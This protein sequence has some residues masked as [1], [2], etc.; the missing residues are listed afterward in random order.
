VK[1]MAAMAEP[2]YIDVAPHNPSGPI[3]NAATLQLAGCI[4][5]F[6]ILEIMLNDVCWR[7]E[8]TDEEVAFQS[9]NIL[10]P[11]KPGLGLDINEENCLKYPFKPI[12]LRHYKGTLTDVRP[13]GSQTEYYFKNFG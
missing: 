12:Q 11:D 9:G 1:K 4:N 3:A 5:N 6:R 7:K 10:I 2:Y 8:L 13:K